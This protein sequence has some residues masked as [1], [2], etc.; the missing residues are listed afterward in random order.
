MGMPQPDQAIFF[1]R[2]DHRDRVAPRHEKHDQRTFHQ[3]KVKAGDVLQIRARDQDD[4]IDFGPV[5][6]P[7]QSF[8]ARISHPNH[9][10][11]D[12]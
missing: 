11:S 5:R 9:A 2:G 4:G 3:V 7:V 1:Q 12:E 10:P 8:Y 6:Q